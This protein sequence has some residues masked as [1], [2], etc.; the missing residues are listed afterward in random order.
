MSSPRTRRVLKDLKAKDDNNSCFECNAHNPQ[1]VSVTYGIFICLECSGKHRG[2]GVHLSFVRSASMDKWKD[3]ELEK[4]KVGGNRNCKIFFEMQPDYN[5]SWSLQQK[6]NSKAAALYRDKIATEA[7]GKPWSMS[8]SSAKNY[9]PNSLGASNYSSSS[10]SSYSN[11]KPLSSGSYYDEPSSNSYQTAGGIS[12]DQLKSQTNDFFSRKQSENMSR[13]ENLPPSQG[14]RYSGFGNTIDP[15]KSDNN[16]FFSS[17]TSGLSSLTL[18]VGKFAS[19]AKEN[20]VKLGS[21]AAAQ[22]SELTKTVNEKVKEG[23]LV[24]SI[25]NAGSKA[26][27]NV[28]TYLSSDQLSSF[29]NSNS[30]MFGRSDYQGVPGENGHSANTSNNLFSDD[31]NEGSFTRS[32]NSPKLRQET[33][34]YKKA[35][36]KDDDWS[37]D[38]NWETSKPAAKS[39][40][41]SSNDTTIKKTN[42]ASKSKDLMNFDDDQWETIEPSKSK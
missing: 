21:T 12:T 20:V 23:T 8:E 10:S 26:W 2:L 13:P 15:P 3:I 36:E 7:T 41:N 16:D 30:T 38:S 24:H 29:A 25:S 17:F 5:P 14:G 39:K 6:Y 4:M 19:V 28:S 42:N 1:W 37:W 35:D 22:A 32:R 18:N 27:S 31:S 34:N 40:S 9:T 33:S 11:S